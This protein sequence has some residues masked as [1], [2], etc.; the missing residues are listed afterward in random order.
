[1]RPRTELIF[2][3]VIDPRVRAV[4]ELVNVATYYFVQRNVLNCLRPLCQTAI[5]NYRATIYIKSTHEKAVLHIIDCG[6]SQY[7]S[8]NIRGEISKQETTKKS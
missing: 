2:S 1:M 4:M 7:S 8:H 6:N 5:L 3:M